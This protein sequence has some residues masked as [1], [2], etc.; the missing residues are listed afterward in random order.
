MAQRHTASAVI[1]LYSPTL[2]RTLV[3]ALRV[4]DNSLAGFSKWF[5]HTKTVRVAGVLRTRDLPLFFLLVLVMLLQFSFAFALLLDWARNNTAGVWAFSLATFLAMPLVTALCLVLCVGLRR[6]LWYAVHPK[7]VGKVVVGRILEHQVRQLRRRHH[8]TVVA[9]AGSVGKTSTKHAIA[10]VLGQTLRV[11]YQVGNYNDRTTVP[12]I[13]FNQVQ[14]HILNV[15]GWMK[16][17]G[18]NAAAIEHPYPYDVVVIELGTDGPNQMKHFAYLKP[19]ITVLT[20]IAPEHMAYFGTLDAVAQEELVVFDFS[21]HVLVNTDDTPPIYL[22]GRHYTA[23]GL[24]ANA[25]HNYYASQRPL[26]LRGQELVVDMPTSEVTA[27]V[28]A[29]GKQGA[30]CSLAAVAVADKLGMS[31]KDIAAGLA[32]V[33]PMPGRMQIVEGIKQATII[34]D[35]YNASPVAAKAALDVLYAT[36]A[37]RRIAILGSMNELGSYARTAHIEVGHY[38]DPNKLDM[39][40]TLGHEARR[41]LAPAARER[42]CVVHSFTN[43]AACAAF[44]RKHITPRTVVLAK[45]SQN[46]VYAEEVVKQLLAH[47]ADSSRLVRQSSAWLRKKSR[48]A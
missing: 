6:L 33:Q 25:V 41:W 29:I 37:S 5:L 47:P 30:I 1:N 15:F 42:G 19:D 48:S 35:T 9:V 45:G 44:V 43:R 7:T 13:F 31:R 18:E 21:E 3:L 2:A 22:V 36:R 4:H 26:G 11:R 32:R 10:Q 38:C 23:Y 40:V 39:V 28:S 20:A 17:F 24:R 14:P 16:L 46:G 12:L 34:D 8:V 27:R